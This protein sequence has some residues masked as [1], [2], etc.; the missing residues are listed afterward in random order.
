MG[1]NYTAAKD[2]PHL[3]ASGSSPT[4]AADIAEI[5][6]WFTA[7]RTFRKFATQ[8]A[9][10]AE[11]GQ[12]DNDLGVVENIDG[13]T[14]KYDSSAGLWRMYGIPRFADSAAIST[15]IT[16]P[17]VTWKAL[18]ADTGIIYRYS[19]SAWEE[20]ESDWI[21]FV[22]TLGANITLGGG[23]TNTSKYRWVGGVPQWKG[24]ITFGTAPAIGGSP[25]T[26]TITIPP[27]TIAAL[28]HAYQDFKGTVT[29]YDT[30]ATLN[31]RGA[32][33]ADN[34]STTVARIYARSAVDANLSATVPFGAV[35]AVGDTIEYDIVFEV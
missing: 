33:V 21:T 22:P 2:Q 8:A 25:T 30:S 4:F 3:I 1:V 19:G 10:I 23:G 24:Q 31:Y 5:V 29:L 27:I 11:T 13:A 15:A 7:G 35:F 14:F 18:A 17:V 26:N 6:D 20:W 34:T 12:D 32:M 16:V 28:R 9:M